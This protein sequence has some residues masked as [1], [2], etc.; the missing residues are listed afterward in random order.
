MGV[1]HALD[2]V[3]IWVREYGHQTARL[4][5]VCGPCAQYFTVG[6]V[7]LYAPDG[8]TEMDKPLYIHYETTLVWWLNVV[9][10]YYT[11]SKH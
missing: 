8:L 3:P 1:L 11:P 7:G 4:Y 5:R 2:R 10:I 9:W 6:W